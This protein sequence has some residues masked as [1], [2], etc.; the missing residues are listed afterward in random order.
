MLDKLLGRDSNIINTEDIAQMVYHYLSG[1]AWVYNYYTK[2]NKKT[3]Q[4]WYYPYHY[5]PLIKDMYVVLKSI[6]DNGDTINGWQDNGESPMSAVHQLITIIPPQLANI[7]PEEAR[8]LMG[9]LSPIADYMPTDFHVDKSDVNESW[10]GI[11]LL[12][13]VDPYN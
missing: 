3:N 10:R 12:P 7:L 13:F 1:F 2:G 11:A 8:E 6:L 5:T 4:R 9:P